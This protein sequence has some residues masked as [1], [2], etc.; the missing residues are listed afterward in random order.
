MQIFLFRA[1]SDNPNVVLRY[2]HFQMAKRF[3]TEI[4]SHEFCDRI[5]HKY[6]R[7][8]LVIND[9]GRISN[10]DKNQVNLPGVINAAR[11]LN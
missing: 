5:S 2:A 9:S 7:V 11:E 8:A 3:I 4:K 10:T 1:I 6:E